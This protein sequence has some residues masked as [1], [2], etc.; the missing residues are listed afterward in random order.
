MNRIPYQIALIFLIFVPLLEGGQ[1][2]IAFMVYRLTI[3]L[4]LTLYIFEGIRKGSLFLYRSG[5]EAPIFAFLLISSLTTLRSPYL[6]MSLQWL[7]NIIFAFLFFYLILSIARDEERILPI[8]SLLFIMG[9]AEA[10]I[11]LWQFFFLGI[12]RAKGTFSNPNFLALYILATAQLGLGS[13]FSKDPYLLP[14]LPRIMVG[15]FLLIMLPAIITTG[16]RGGFVAISSILILFSLLRFGRRSI[17]PILLIITLILSLPNPISTR[18]FHSGS[19]DNL[20]PKVWSISLEEMLREPL[21]IGLGIYKYSSY[22]HDLPINGVITRYGKRVGSVHNEYLQIGAE[23]GIAGLSVF[24]W[25]VFKLIRRLQKGLKSP[26]WLDRFDLLLGLACGIIAIFIHAIFDAILQE[27]AL[28]ILLATYTS[29]F[30]AMDQEK[31]KTQPVIL[32]TS[33]IRHPSLII[34]LAFVISALIIRPNVAWYLFENGNRGLQEGD[35]PYAIKRFEQAI[36]LDPWNANHH[37]M[38]AYTYFQGFKIIGDRGFF[39]KAI[40]ELEYAISLNPLEGK[41]PAAIGT[42]YYDLALKLKDPSQKNKALQKALIY[43]QKGAELHPFYAVR[44]NELGMVYKR[45]GKYEMALKNFE[46]AIQLEPN[47][48]PARANL[49]ILHKESGRYQDAKREFEAIRLIRDRYKD[50]PISPQEGQYLAI[51]EKKIHDE[52][53]SLLSLEEKNKD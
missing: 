4:L 52:I 36:L 13:L 3:I 47:F 45:L 49:A 34:C 11:A 21:G 31:K 35:F 53:R 1:T 8:L 43:Y 7:L 44:Y 26:L 12:P 6:N 14:Y 10:I 15:I 30:L 29:L 37:D 41:F 40:S 19:Q 23:L 28:V 48:L 20:R 9:F 38:L 50:A 51:D 17:W 22:K 24:L 39:E 46:K 2:Y 16:S 42:L 33:H 27:P 25:G 18:L 32:P 5:F